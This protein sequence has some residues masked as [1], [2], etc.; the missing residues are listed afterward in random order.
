M[1]RVTIVLPFV[2]NKS[3]HPHFVFET[4]EEVSVF[5][6]VCLENGHRIETKKEG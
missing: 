1:Y 4:L 6:K 2:A 5:S 3:N